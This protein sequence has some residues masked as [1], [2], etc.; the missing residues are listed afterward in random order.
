MLLNGTEEDRKI[1][2]EKLNNQ[3]IIGAQDFDEDAHSDIFSDDNGSKKQVEIDKE[4]Q[5]SDE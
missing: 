2:K 5:Q 1:F 3:K 4:S